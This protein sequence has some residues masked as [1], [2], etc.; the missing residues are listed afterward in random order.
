[1][2][3]F[4][5]S[6]CG[7]GKTKEGRTQGPGRPDDC[8]FFTWKTCVFDI[9]SDIQHVFSPISGESEVPGALCPLWWV[10]SLVVKSFTLQ[11]PS[12]F[13]KSLLFGISSGAYQGRIPNNPR[14]GCV[15]T[16]HDYSAHFREVT[17]SK[18]PFF[19]THDHDN[20]D[21]YSAKQ[22]S[23]VVYILTKTEEKNRRRNS[24]GLNIF[25]WFKS[26]FWWLNSLY[27]HKSPCSCS[28]HAKNI[29]NTKLFGFVLPFFGGSPTQKE[30]FAAGAHWK[31]LARPTRHCVCAAL[32]PDS[33]I[34]ASE[35]S[36]DL[37]NQ[38]LVNY[39]LLYVHWDSYGCVNCDHNSI[40]IAEKKKL[41]KSPT[42]YPLVI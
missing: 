7:H 15:T 20:W 27:L 12:L 35:T 40:S 31:A 1:M 42:S 41:L 10:K 38:W 4:G 3:S 19:L 39:I 8:L 32:L 11:S 6:R 36:L 29:Q 5:S 21:I 25:W 9:E 37:S 17:V 13:L 34:F 33:G 14:M 16:I 18:V 26:T 23:W 22:N 24:L 28:L 30:M 2:N